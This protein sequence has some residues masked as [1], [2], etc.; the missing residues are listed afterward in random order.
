VLALAFY[1][2]FAIYFLITHLPK[3][4][5]M[6]EVEPVGIFEAQP[7]DNI[8]DVAE[9]IVKLLLFTNRLKG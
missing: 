2:Y 7:I 1:S 9:K 6:I 3:N 5:T 4:E 8:S